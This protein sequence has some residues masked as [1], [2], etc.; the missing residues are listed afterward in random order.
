MLFC[1]VHR[2]DRNFTSRRGIARYRVAKPRSRDASWRKSVKISPRI[3]PRNDASDRIKHPRVL[4]IFS[5]TPVGETGISLAPAAIRRAGISQR[6]FL[7]FSGRWFLFVSSA[8][9]RTTNDKINVTLSSR[10]AAEIG[11]SL[12]ARAMERCPFFGIVFFFFFSLSP[13]SFS[14]KNST[15]PHRRGPDF[16]VQRD[17][18]YLRSR[19]LAWFHSSS[20]ARL[21][22]IF[23]HS[24][25]KETI[26]SLS[27]SLAV[28][29]ASC[30]R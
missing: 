18:V 30:V 23:I 26:L 10:S 14:Q 4:V 2:R 13:F 28:V 17:R 22:D 1:R 6:F 5:S 29:A 9:R 11:G 15:W 12:I 24:R 27:L 21:R 7:R 8:Q 3:S 16:D 19:V 25:A 20:S